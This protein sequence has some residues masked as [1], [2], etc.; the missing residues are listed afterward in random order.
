MKIQDWLIN[1][2]DNNT[3]FSHNKIKEQIHL[4]FLLEKWI[5][6][7][8][9]VLLITEIEDNFKIKFSGDEFH[10]DKFSTIIGLNDIIQSKL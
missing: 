7:L 10:S 1:W 2:F 5:D 3:E 4:S 6:S 9:F 8:K